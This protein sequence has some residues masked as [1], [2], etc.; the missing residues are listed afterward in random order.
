M[1]PDLNGIAQGVERPEAKVN[2]EK[3]IIGFLYSVSRTACGEYWPLRIGDNTIGRSSKCDICLQEA[4]VSAEHAVLNIRQMKTTRQLIISLTVRG[5]NG[6][7]VNKDEVGFDAVQCSN[8]DYITIGDNYV[9]YLIII[10]A[11]KLG[12]TVSK[13]FQA[14]K[15]LHKKDEPFDPD[16]TEDPYRRTSDTL[17]TVTLDG[18]NKTPVDKTQ[19]M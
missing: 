17:G 16:I 9:L 2:T 14:T 10:D 3:P 7:F 11:N 13:D 6:G 5:D 15:P 1:H 12:L 8:G 19:G 18:N 4:T